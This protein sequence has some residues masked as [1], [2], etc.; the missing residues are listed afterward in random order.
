MRSQLH[1]E[2]A[3]SDLENT[4]AHED[5]VVANAFAEK[6]MCNA[7]ESLV[8]FDLN[9]TLLYRPWDGVVVEGASEA[10]TVS[11]LPVGPSGISLRMYLMLPWN[12]NQVYV[13]FSVALFA[14]HLSP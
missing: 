5:A 4:N 12:I 2:S 6:G 7:I 9:E 14:L 11:E 8:L 3:A 13:C 1:D 10:V